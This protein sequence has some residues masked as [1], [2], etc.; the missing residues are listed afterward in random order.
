M[1]TAPERRNFADIPMTERARNYFEHSFLPRYR[2][3]EEEVSKTPLTVLIWGPGA[4][5]ATIYEKRVQIRGLLREAGYAAVFSEE[6]DAELGNR[7]SFSSK[8]RGLLQAIAADFIVAL[9]ASPGSIAEVHDFAHFLTD[10]GPKMLVFIDAAH[11]SGYS[12]TGAL[13]DL[14]NLYQNVRTYEYPKDIDDCHLATAV[15][16]HLKALR[17]GKWAQTL[18]QQK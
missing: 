16:E 6:L 1:T 10:V 14:R 18:G 15:L 17:C 8:M 5:G 12:Y 3:L 2:Q 4:S 7:W 9:H 13:Q 11:V